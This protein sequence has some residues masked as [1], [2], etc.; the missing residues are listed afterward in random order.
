MK[1]RFETLCRGFFERYGREPSVWV[2][3]PGRVDLMG[4]HTDYNLGYVLTLSIDRDTWIAAAPRDDRSV[5]VAS[6]NAD[7][8]GQFHLDAI[9]HNPEAPWVDYIA[10]TA[11]ALMQ[12]GYPLG[13]CDLLVH[14]T[15][16]LGSGLSSSAALEMAT[17]L[18][19]AALGGWRIEPLEMALIGQRAEHQFVG[20]KCGILDQYTSALGQAESALVLDCRTTTS[21]PAPIPAEIA[22]VICDTRAKRELTGGEYG[23]RRASCE[24]AV[25]ILRPYYPEIEALRDVS[26]AQIERHRAELGETRYA[27]ASFIVAESDRVLRLAQALEQADALA[28]ADLTRDSYLG[29]RDQYAIGT[30]EMEAMWQA[31]WQAPGRL[32]ARQAGAGFGGCMVAFCVADQ[33]DAFGQSVQSAYQTVTGI[34]PTTYAVRPAPGASLLHLPDDMAAD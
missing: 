17:A 25:G 4:S 24:E 19:F 14:S 29:A 27:R 10:G 15:I 1:Q 16:P 33:I 30:P 3:A 34:E 20:V 31:M 23:E 8:A 13:G 32:G 28:I 18:A 12:V 22:V 21:R 6:L 9:A 2:R 11:E 7:T 26:L 5:R